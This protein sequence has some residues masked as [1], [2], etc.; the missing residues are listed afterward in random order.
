METVMFPA[1]CKRVKFTNFTLIELL[2][3]IAIIA[4]LAAI[5]M[6]ALSAARERGKSATCISNM[7]SIMHAFG[8][9]TTDNGDYIPPKVMCVKSW[10]GQTVLPQLWWCIGLMRLK[11]LSAPG[12]YA[13]SDSP[14]EVS[15]VMR[16]PGEPRNFIGTNTSIWNTWK[17]S[18]Y[19]VGTKIGHWVYYTRVERYFFKVTELKNPS[20]NAAIGD[21]GIANSGVFGT[22]YDEIAEGAR[23]NGRMNLA[24]MDQHVEARELAT[25]P[26]ESW[27]TDW[28]RYSFYARKDQQKNWGLY[29]W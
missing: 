14:H 21:K 23:H 12:T 1:A 2:V 16:C 19:G 17:G 3:V 10:S 25:I 22:K 20:R 9:Y 8:A 18:H 11:Y 29:P 5:L 4:I 13:L 24:Y 28:Y 15:G 27:T 6:P 7:K 26:N